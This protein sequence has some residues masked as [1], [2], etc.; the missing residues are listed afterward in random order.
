MSGFW[1]VSRLICAY[2]VPKLDEIVFLQVSGSRTTVPN[3]RT[4]L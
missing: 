3:L 2:H 4:T 1:L